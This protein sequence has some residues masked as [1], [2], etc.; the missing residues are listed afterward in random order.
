MGFE[1]AWESCLLILDGV[2]RAEWDGKKEVL[3]ECYRKTYRT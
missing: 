3:L 2:D 1:S